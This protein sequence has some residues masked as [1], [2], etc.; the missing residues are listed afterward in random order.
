MFPA[1]AQLGLTEGNLA[2]E[3][4]LFE[5][6]SYRVVTE[7]NVHNMQKDKVSEQRLADVL[8]KGDEL[9]PLFSE[10][11]KTLLPSWKKYRSFA[12][13]KHNQADGDIDTYVFN[14]MRILHKELLAIIEQVKQKVNADLLPGREL[15]KV[16]G[17]LLIE[18]LA[19]E[20]LEMSAAT[21]GTMGFAGTDEAIQIEVRSQAFE[22]VIAE[23]KKLYSED[24]I[25]LKAVNKLALRWKFIKST[26]LAY[27]ERSAP[28]AVAKTVGFIRKQ[29]AEI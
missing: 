26:L 20:Y 15:N 8:A 28:F 14:D 23:L 13:E 19:S 29:L 22:H 9:G 11:S 25:K 17:I 1:Q 2:K 27:N 6:N 4:I 3:I 7:F 10:H 16:H 5:A 24:A 12:W 21:F 18:Q